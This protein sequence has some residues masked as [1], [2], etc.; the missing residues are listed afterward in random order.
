MLLQWAEELYCC[1]LAVADIKT[2]LMSKKNIDSIARRMRLCLVR[3][4]LVLLL[5]FGAGAVV[6]AQDATMDAVVTQMA[7]VL[8]KSK[9][10]SVVVFDFVGPDGKTTALGEKLADDFSRAL[11]RSGHKLRIEDRSRIADIVSK[12]QYA[13]DVI[14]IPTFNVTLA[15]DMKVKGFVSGTISL[16]GREVKVLVKSSRTKDSKKIA[17]L[18]FSLALNEESTALLAKTIADAPLPPYLDV[19]DKKDSPPHCISC[20]RADYSSEALARKIQ[21]TVI[22]ETVVGVDGAISDIRVIRPMPY[23]LTAAAIQAVR[24]WRLSPATGQDGKPI[25]VRQVIEVTFQFS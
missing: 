1:P 4:V 2:A 15:Y 7:D 16:E 3:I 12:G 22:L 24:S 9:Q 18:S 23:G 6:R 20:P 11:S 8:S 17:S 19:D 14:Y 21:G 10:N 5:A 13:P 25:R